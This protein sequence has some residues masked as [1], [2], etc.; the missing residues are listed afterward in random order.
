MQI[1]TVSPVAPDI[2]TLSDRFKTTSVPSSIGPPRS[3]NSLEHTQLE[4]EKISLEALLDA[5]RNKNATLQRRNQELELQV[6]PQSNHDGKWTLEKSNR[7]ISL[8][9]TKSEIDENDRLTAE[10]VKL[11]EKLMLL[12]LRRTDSSLAQK[13]ST[14]SEENSRIKR[15]IENE[16][17]EGMNFKLNQRVMLDSEMSNTSSKSEFLLREIEKLRLELS[18]QNKS[19]NSLL[20]EFNRLKNQEINDVKKIKQL[21]KHAQSL[22][23]KVASL[24]QI[25]NSLFDNFSKKSNKDSLSTISA[26][27]TSSFDINTHD[28]TIKSSPSESHKSTFEMARSHPTIS[29]TYSK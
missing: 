29:S 6:K 18:K 14:L 10:N 25:N 22:K 27:Y 19:Q 5:E 23:S 26:K 15:E 4:S 8:E 28:F 13:F 20:D 21:Q 9:R 11:K 12:Q 16:K 1:P 24:T 3:S 17:L 7:D 2:L